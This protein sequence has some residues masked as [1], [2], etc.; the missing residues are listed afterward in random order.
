MDATKRMQMILSATPAMLAKVDA[1]LLGD[2]THVPKVDPDV[3]TCTLTEAARRMG[4]S[5]PTIYRLIERKAIRAVEL[6]G[7]SRVSL[8]SLFDYVANGEKV[9]G[10]YNTGDEA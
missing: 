9:R 7:V 5:R 4:V 6:N 3:R 10:N 1:V 8:Q 2:D